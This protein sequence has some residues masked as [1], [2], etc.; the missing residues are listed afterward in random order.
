MSEPSIDPTDLQAAGH[1]EDA[2]T[3]DHSDKY[4]DPRA[5]VTARGIGIGLAVVMLGLAGSIGS[6]YARKTRLGE[7]TRF[8]G[9][10][11][12][13][14]LQLGER[15]EMLPVGTSTIPAVELTATPGLGHLR[16]ALL[17]ERNYQWETETDRP[18]LEYC[19]QGST[20]P[21]ASTSESTSKPK[22]LKQCIRLRLTDP[23]AH[24][25]DTVEID[26]DLNGGW[27]GPSDGSRRVQA[28]D[29]VRPKLQNYFGTI[30]NVEQLRFDMRK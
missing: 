24:R 8:W 6:I 22:A 3:V 25:F 30:V 15:I 18:A 5:K 14:A 28:T 27:I 2:V 7:S 20:E 19:G 21:P 12:I 13:T 17:D 11:V 4:N 26:I 10:D 16:R 23:T 29:Y 1:P 9:E